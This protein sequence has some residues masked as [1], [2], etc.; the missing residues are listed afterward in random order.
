VPLVEMFN[1]LHERAGTLLHLDLN[2][3]L[4]TE[5]WLGESPEAFLDRLTAD[6]AWVHVAGHENVPLP[7]DDHS[8]MPTAACMDLLARVASSAPVILEWDRERPPLQKL[9]PAISA[10][11]VRR[12]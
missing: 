11:Q 9:L 12:A 7:I 1:Q 2:N 10:E 6:I 5:R 3:L 4:V 8:G